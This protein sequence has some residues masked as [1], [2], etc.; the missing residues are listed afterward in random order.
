M[1]GCYQRYEEGNRFVI[2]TTEANDSMKPVHNRMPVILD[3]CELN[4][5]VYDDSYMK[6]VLN[7]T[8]VE[9][10]REQEYEQQ[11]FIF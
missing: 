4:G 1:A 9:L 8:P 5:W 2:L 11:S 3:R 10:S 6:Y 7:R